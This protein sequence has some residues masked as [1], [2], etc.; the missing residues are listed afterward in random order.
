MTKITDHIG[1]GKFCHF[2]HYQD[3]NLWYKTDSGFEFPVPVA[4]TGTGIFLPTDKSIFFMRWI[5]KHMK[6]IEDAKTSQE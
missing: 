5:R 4:D 1:E 6:Y 3:G 2:L